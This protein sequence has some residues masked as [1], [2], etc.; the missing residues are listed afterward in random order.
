MLGLGL[1]FLIFALVFDM[2]LIDT[3]AINFVY[4]GDYGFIPLLVIMSVQFSNQVIRIDEELDS[5]RKTLEQMVRER[6]ND[7]E[8]TAAALR[9]SE[10]QTRDFKLTLMWR[11]SRVRER[12]YP[13]SGKHAAKIFKVRLWRRTGCKSFRLR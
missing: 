10:R 4:L 1:L 3:G 5:Y 8:K 13:C 2:L 6:T 12:K 9:R 7:L 11:A